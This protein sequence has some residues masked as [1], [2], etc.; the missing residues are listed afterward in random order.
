MIIQKQLGIYPLF[1]VKSMNST[2]G[3]HTLKWLEKWIVYFYRFFFFNLA[4]IKKAILIKMLCIEELLLFIWEVAKWRVFFIFT[5]F[6]FDAD[7]IPML[8]MPPTVSMH[9]WNVTPWCFSLSFVYNYKKL[10]EI[11][12]FL[13]L[14]CCGICTAGTCQTHDL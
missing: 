13:L 5:N 3:D 14:Y 8:I 4:S 12:W 6:Q 1:F 10:M 9:Q 11:I 2:C 7:V